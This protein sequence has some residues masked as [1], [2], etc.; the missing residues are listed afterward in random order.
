MSCFSY[1]VIIPE[2]EKDV[3]IALLIQLGVE[4]FI[5]YD[6][7]FEAFVFAKQNLERDVEN[8]LDLRKLRYQKI[9]HETRDWNVE[10]E[11]N[12]SP[13]TIG[14]KLIVRAPFH[15][16]MKN[17]DYDLLI[18]PKMAFGT[19]HHETTSMILEWM[20]QN[21]FSGKSVLD[22]GC[23]T[24]I[25]GIFARMKQAATSCFIDNDPIALENTKEN[26]LLNKILSSE[27][28]IGSYDE[29][30]ETQFDLILANITRNI[31]SEGLHE[32][33]VHLAD[34][35]K[36]ILSGFLVQDAEI[37]QN[38]IRDNQL[39]LIGEMQKGEWLC[40]IAEKQ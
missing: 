11:K 17:F 38:L 12:F 18:A 15:S 26:L 3:E 31:L 9:E 1:R 14:E 21:D 37:M 25:L 36:V 5:E 28:R 35:G 7:G 6:D 16:V 13:I 23:G 24:G 32:L 10:W 4:N 2:S 30:P 33:V 27:V 40:F 20:L 34:K 8:H 19:G 39:H 22:F 29:I